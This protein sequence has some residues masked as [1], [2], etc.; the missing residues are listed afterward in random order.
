MP[1]QPVR[2]PARERL[3]DLSRFGAGVPEGPTASGSAIDGVDGAG[4]TCSP[5]ELA[6]AL[7][8]GAAQWPGC[9]PMT[10]QPSTGSCRYGAAGSRRAVLAW[11]PS[12][13]TGGGAAGP[14]SPLRPRAAVAARVRPGTNLPAT[15]C[16]GRP[17]IEAQPVRCWCGRRSSYRP[18]LAGGLGAVDLLTSASTQPLAAMAIRARRAANRTPEPAHGPCSPGDGAPTAAPRRVASG[19]D[20]RDRPSLRW[21]PGAGQPCA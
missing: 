18:A 14:R 1:V 19:A 4:K 11:T 8:V 21:R 10:L 16:C 12:T 9:G 15:S 3:V 20:V 6:G 13:R 7:H 17:S 5:S 2:S